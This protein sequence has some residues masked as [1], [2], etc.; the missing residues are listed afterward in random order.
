LPV[1]LIF[2]ADICGGPKVIG[3]SVVQIWMRWPGWSAPTLVVVVN[4]RP[5][6]SSMRVKGSTCTNRVPPRGTHSEKAPISSA[7]L[8]SGGSPPG[9][10][11]RICPLNVG[12]SKPPQ[13]ARPT[14]SSASA[15]MPSAN[16]S[17]I[18]EL[19]SGRYRAYCTTALR[20][21]LISL[22]EYAFE[23]M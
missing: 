5:R 4:R 2:T 23:S 3:S 17:F 21:T 10:T 20:R 19:R 8:A 12:R 22:L 15:P 13:P 16:R 7:P 18:V 14:I 6:A 1:I 9:P 11:T